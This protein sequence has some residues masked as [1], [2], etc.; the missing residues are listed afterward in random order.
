MLAGVYQLI[1]VFKLIRR[2]CEVKKYIIVLNLR[3]FEILEN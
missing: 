3:F 1:I 2:S